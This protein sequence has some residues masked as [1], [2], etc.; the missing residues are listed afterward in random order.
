MDACFC[1]LLEHGQQLSR[2][3]GGQIDDDDDRLGT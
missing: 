2:D 1:Q 3:V